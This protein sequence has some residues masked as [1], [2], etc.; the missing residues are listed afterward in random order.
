[1]KGM[2]QWKESYSADMITL[3]FFFAKS[4]TD[5]LAGMCQGQKSLY[6][7]HRIL[8]NTCSKWRESYGG[9]MISS[10]DGQI[11]KVKPV[12][13]LNFVGAGYSKI[14]YGQYIYGFGLIVEGDYNQSS[15][16]GR[17]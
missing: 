6:T 4:S 7:T 17:H 10:T 5:E 16:K 9:D 13:P 12:Y 8:V 1:M 3:S 2:P 11:E 15:Q 14:G